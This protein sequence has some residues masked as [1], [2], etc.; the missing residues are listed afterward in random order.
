M[1]K[2]IVLIVCIAALFTSCSL[3]DKKS[4]TAYADTEIETKKAMMSDILKSFEIEDAEI[5]SM[6]HLRYG[7][8]E[9]KKQLHSESYTGTGLTMEGPPGEE[10]SVP[11]E[12]AEGL[13][14]RYSNFDLTVDYD[15]SRKKS[16]LPR[17][18][19]FSH[20]RGFEV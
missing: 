19:L 8:P 20:N 13:N 2:R 1:K 11:P 14:S 12:D 15:G 9:L 6:A 5:Y 16:S 17:L 4:I 18:Y 10:G 3:M 7:S